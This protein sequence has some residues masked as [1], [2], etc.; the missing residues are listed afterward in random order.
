MKNQ[1]TEKDSAGSLERRVRRR[2]LTIES[3]PDDSPENVADLFR[4][5]GVARLNDGP[6]SG[7]CVC[8]RA[9]KSPSATL[10][11]TLRKLNLPGPVVDQLALCKGAIAKVVAV[12]N[13]FLS[14]VVMLVCGHGGS[15]SRL[16]PKLRH[17]E[18]RRKR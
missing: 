10:E 2:V 16:K 14:L 17:A 3:G 1:P 5:S 12:N 18:E 6:E 9:S 8:C 13:D 4:N 11:F 15:P 7:Q